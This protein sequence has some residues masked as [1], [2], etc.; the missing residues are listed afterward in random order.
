MTSAFALRVLQGNPGTYYVKRLDKQIGLLEQSR[1][2]MWTRSFP[3]D[4]QD[5]RLFGIRRRETVWKS[6]AAA[7]VTVSFSF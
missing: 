7:E 1:I 2:L 5:K 3:K 4:K 6:Q